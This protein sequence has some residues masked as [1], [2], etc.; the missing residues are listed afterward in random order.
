[1]LA[2]F[3]LF[4]LFASPKFAT[5]GNMT[6]LIK[7]MPVNG[8][9]AIGMTI[10]IITGG[11]DLSVGS[12]MALAGVVTMAV[13]PNGAPLAIL[14]GVG[15]GVAIGIFNGTIIAYFGINPFI[16]TLGAMAFVRGIALGSTDSR[17]IPCGN[18]DFINYVG[19][20]FAA[21]IFMVMLILA[22][23]FFLKLTRSGHNIYIFGSNK[24]A[25]FTAGVNMKRTQMTAYVLCSICASFAGIFLS[26]RLGTGSP[27]IANDAALLAIT[28]VILG[29][30]SLAGGSG[31]VVRT[32]TGIL[33]LGILTNILNL[34]GVTTYFQ[35][36]IK[37]LLVVSVVALEAPKLIKKW[38]KREFKTVIAEQ[39]QS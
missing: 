26:A 32:L 21:A 8:I 13:L 3:I 25:G 36:L 29:G 22:M 6:N 20:S 37:G 19:L 24:E 30:T 23:Q 7:Q 28:A 35:T 14:A 16:A 11:F 27:I 5:I 12:V 17:P 9:V 33:I 4:A 10:V 18:I 15:V 2:A 34:I 31:S 38:N 1:M 39:E